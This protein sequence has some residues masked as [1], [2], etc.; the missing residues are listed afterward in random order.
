MGG[1]TAGALDVISGNTNDGVVINGSSDNLV[2]G[3][4]IGIDDTGGRL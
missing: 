2:E 4:Y 3:D 1:A